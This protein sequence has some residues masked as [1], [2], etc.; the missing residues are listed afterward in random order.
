MSICTM[1][2]NNAEVNIPA[3]KVDISR[4]TKEYFSQF[5]SLFIHRQGF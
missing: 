2:E 3:P 5:Q 1:T 4:T